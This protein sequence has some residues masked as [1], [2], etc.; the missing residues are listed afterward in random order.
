MWEGRSHLFHR[1][2]FVLPDVLQQLL[3]LLLAQR[4]FPLHTLELQTEQ[5]VVGNRSELS[6]L[7]TLD[8][9]MKPHTYDRDWDQKLHISA[10]TFAYA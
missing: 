8:S 2:G 4:Q 3:V 6:H 5:T 10:C 1:P 9:E 7:A